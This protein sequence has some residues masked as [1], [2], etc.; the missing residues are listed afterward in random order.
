MNL[1][2]EGR[3][4]K[5]GDGGRTREK[6]EESVETQCWLKVQATMLSVTPD[7]RIVQS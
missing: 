1:K 5:A 7:Y 3:R 6:N 2:V 4:Q